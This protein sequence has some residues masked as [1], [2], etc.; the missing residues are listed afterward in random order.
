MFNQDEWEDDADLG[1]FIFLSLDYELTGG[2][3]SLTFE[4]DEQAKSILMR[5]SAMS[6]IIFNNRKML[7]GIMDLKT[8]KLTDHTFTLKEKYPDA[9]IVGQV[10]KVVLNLWLN[11]LLVNDDD[12]SNSMQQE[13]EL[14]RDRS[15]SE[16]IEQGVFIPDD[17][18]NYGDADLELIEIIPKR[19][20]FTAWNKP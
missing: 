2:D 1:Y 14:Q 5:G 6:E 8:Y 9:V 15:N 11:E 7:F 19:K 20:K 18:L 12:N 16:L 10:A 17:A 4:E 3:L 13:N